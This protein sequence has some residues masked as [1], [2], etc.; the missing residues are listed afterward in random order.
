MRI[1]RNLLA[2]AALLAMTACSAAPGDPLVY[3]TTSGKKY[4][5]KNCR[6][7]HGS[8]GIKLSD[9]KKKGYTPCG[10]CKPPR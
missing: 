9:A 10:V 1:R 3:V 6:L 7:K 5:V 8:K 2:L 4:H